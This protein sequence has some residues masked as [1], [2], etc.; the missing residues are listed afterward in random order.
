L[1]AAAAQQ[2]VEDNTQNAM[3]KMSACFLNEGD[4]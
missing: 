3:G 1:D 2:K 4:N